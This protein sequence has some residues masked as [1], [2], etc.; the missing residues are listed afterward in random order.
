MF[1]P[2]VTRFDTYAIPAG[3]EAR[4]YMKTILDTKTFQNWKESALKETWDLPETEV[5]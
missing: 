5:A 2:V 1:A 3:N 4:A